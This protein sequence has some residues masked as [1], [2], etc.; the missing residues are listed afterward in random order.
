MSLGQGKGLL[1]VGRLDHLVAAGAQQTRSHPAHHGLVLHE[2]DPADAGEVARRA[3]AGGGLGGGLEC[4]RRGVDRQEDA[5]H[6][7]LAG[8]R[9]RRYPAVGLLDHA[10]DRGQ[11][12]TGALAH[13]FG[14][15]ERLEDLGQ[16]FGRDARPIV[17]HLQQGKL[18]GVGA[19][20][21]QG[22]GRLE[23]QPGGADLDRAAA[24][25]PQRIAGVD[26]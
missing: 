7:A 14:G 13:R 23:G 19:S 20:V 12:E 3:A 16:G 4:Q 6:R 9:R 8:R 26:H 17:S 11:P 24:L 1:A 22:L 10:V 5:E 18:G 2:Q 25:G 21:A 15:E